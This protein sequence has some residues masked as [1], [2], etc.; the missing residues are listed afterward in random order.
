MQHTFR[1]TVLALAAALALVGLPALAE[2]GPRPAPPREPI[3]DQLG[4][5][6]LE[7]LLQAMREALA[8]VPYAMPEINGQG[9]IIIR[10]LP[11]RPETPRPSPRRA[12]PS[13][14]DETSACDPRGRRLPPAVRAFRVPRRGGKP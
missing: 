5:M 14:P 13:N 12:P 4:R 10:R 1:T 3:P 6:A 11:P 7:A 2:D 8:A 9:D